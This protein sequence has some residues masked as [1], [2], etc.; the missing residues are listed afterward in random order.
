MTDIADDST[1]SAS[2][3]SGARPAG[4][5]W[6]GLALIGLAWGLTQPLSRMAMSTGHHPMGVAF[7]NALICLLALSLLLLLRRRRLPISRR[8]L[9]FYL[10]CGFLGTA[11][12]NALSFRAFVELPVGVLS[13]II[14][15][16]P[17]ATLLLAWG[18]GVERPEARR[19]V[20]L[21]L[22][23]AAIAAIALPE[24]SL[25]DPTKAVFILLPAVVVLSY[26]AET[27]FIAARR[28][29]GLD[30][31][32]ILTGLF[33]GAVMLLLPLTALL[34]AWVR[35]WPAGAAELS[36]LGI[37]LLH[38]FAYGG[39]VWLIGKAGPVFASQVGYIVTI[40]GVLGGILVF[41]ERHSAWIWAALVLMF[42]GL[43]LVRPR[44]RD[45]SA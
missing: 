7:L 37:S 29:A 13:I 11:L 2:G 3:A 14:A 17:M 23:L 6:L 42:A 32:T 26:A 27:V 40:T 41:G 20:G 15:C 34:G 19:L 43:T 24:T 4:L 30:A 31:L 1:A 18:A 44:K 28:P 10:I 12:P 39:F 22:G 25:P 45:Q 5:A 8:H 35:P 16:V 21:G 9:I 36:I 38:I 33:L